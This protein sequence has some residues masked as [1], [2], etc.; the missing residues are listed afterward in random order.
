[1]L[2]LKLQV[3]GREVLDSLALFYQGYKREGKKEKDADKDKY[4]IESDR[5]QARSP[6][7]SG[8]SDHRIPGIDGR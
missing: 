4:Q 8:Y 6:L 2:P 1:L 3:C 5:A 7:K